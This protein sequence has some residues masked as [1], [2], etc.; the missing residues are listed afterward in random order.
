MLLAVV[1]VVEI[2]MTIAA[3]IIIVIIIIIIIL[4]PSSSLT[5]VDVVLLPHSTQCVRPGGDR[6]AT[7]AVI[8][9]AI[10]IVIVEEES[11]LLPRPRCVLLMWMLPLLL[12]YVHVVDPVHHVDQG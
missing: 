7:F 8:R 2:T 11:H 1:I 3:I 6:I 5:F 12:T 4:P 9:V 10:Q